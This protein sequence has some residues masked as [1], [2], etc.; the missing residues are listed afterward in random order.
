MKKKMFFLNSI[1]MLVFLLSVFVLQVTVIREINASNTTKEVIR[2]TE[3]YAHFLQEGGSIIDVDNEIRV[4]LLDEYGNVEHDSV[5]FEELV[6]KNY[7]D[8]PEII[9]ASK[10]K[11][12]VFTRRNKNLNNIKFFYCAHKIQIDGVT[13]YV[14]IAVP[15]T[16]MYVVGTKMIVWV[17]AI[18]VLLFIL[19]RIVYTKLSNSFMEPYYKAIDGLKNINKGNFKQIPLDKKN[20]DVE[21]FV[22]DINEVGLKLQK[23]MQEV[24]QERNRLRYV[25]DHT[26]N[27]IFVMNQNG[28]FIMVNNGAKSL[29]AKYNVPF[30]TNYKECLTAPIVNK[31]S[32]NIDEFLNGEKKDIHFNIEA[33]GSHFDVWGRKTDVDRYIIIVSDVTEPYKIS[34]MR[35]DFFANASHE[36]KTPLTSVKGFNELALM[37]EKDEEIKKYLHLIEKDVDRM[38]NVISDML[39][40]ASLEQDIITN[41]VEVDLIKVANEVVDILEPAITKKS[42][43][44][45]IKG[46]GSVFASKDDIYYLIKNL[47]E[48][49]IRY[50]NN[51]GNIQLKVDEIDN[52]VILTVS[53]NGIGIDKQH[54]S[55]IFERFYRV[56][57]SRSRTSGGTGLGLAIVEYICNR[58]N[59]SIDFT[60]ELGKGTEFVITFT[61][62]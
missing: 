15:E 42:H 46:K 45:S 19:E 52:K 6:N 37:K 35:K 3:T 1:I 43:N 51:G 53:D 33:E 50:T 38:N 41:E 26:K 28:H 18:I 4:T 16:S 47:I 36:L 9:S 32:G 60:S 14:R 22:Q 21:V 39:K 17:V 56:D 20:K 13:K 61:K 11:I 49:S 23:Y 27:A 29:L 7:S 25:F 58:Y 48:N 34:K 12:E 62:D 10:G 44:L 30:V 59:A 55:R 40:L 57:K 31:Y 24:E 54:H 2:L 8:S 5:G